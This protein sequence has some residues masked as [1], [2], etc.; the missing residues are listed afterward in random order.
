MPRVLLVEDD[1]TMLS[2]LSILLDIEGYEI[3]RLEDD[4]E[5]GILSAVVASKPD[6]ILMDVNLRRANGLAV[7][8]CIRQ[9]GECNGV[10]II[11]TSGMDY[12]IECI[13]SGADHF[14]A[15]PFMPDELVESIQRVLS[16]RA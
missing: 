1:P 15:K 7:L 2:L 3:L 8:R 5:D 14:L 12:R 9:Q 11:M 6:L 10:R 13:Q 4:S 16:Q